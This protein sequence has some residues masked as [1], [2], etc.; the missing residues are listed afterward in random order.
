MCV[1]ASALSGDNVS[2][3]S[4]PRFGRGWTIARQAQRKTRMFDEAKRKKEKERG[5]REKELLQKKHSCKDIASYASDELEISERWE[6][7]E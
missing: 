7:T 6:P 3:V 4:H 2:K 1:R 5:K